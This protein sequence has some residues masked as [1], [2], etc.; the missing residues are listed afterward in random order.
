[1]HGRTNV[2]IELRSKYLHIAQMKVNI[3]RVSSTY[4]EF[5]HDL[6]IFPP[7]GL[8]RPTRVIG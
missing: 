7:N 2:K 6:P 4:F 1:M 5:Q 8:N 3:Q